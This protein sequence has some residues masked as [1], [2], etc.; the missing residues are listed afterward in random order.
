M[1]YELPR[2]CNKRGIQIVA[3]ELVK[4]CEQWTKEKGCK[5]FASDCQL[6]N[7]ES[8]RFHTAAG[9]DEV[10]EIVCFAKKI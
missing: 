4:A 10:G 7:E 8:R 2:C 1:C 9:F 6:S 3:K 5:E